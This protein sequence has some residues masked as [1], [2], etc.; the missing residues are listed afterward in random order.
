MLRSSR[1]RSGLLLSGMT[2]QDSLSALY[3]NG[4]SPCS[5]ST[6]KTCFRDLMLTFI[7]TASLNFVELASARHLSKQYSKHAVMEVKDI[8]EDLNSN[9]GGYNGNYPAKPATYP[10]PVPGVPITH[11]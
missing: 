9:N 1:Q 7:I 2:G 8:N 10:T 4:S 5:S 3:G 11:P 6:V